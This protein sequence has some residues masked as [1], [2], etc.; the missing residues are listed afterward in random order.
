MIFSKNVLSTFASYKNACGF[1]Q[2]ILVGEEGDMD[3]SYY[4]LSPE[5]AAN[6]LQINIWIKRNCTQ[7]S[8]SH[9][10][11][12][13]RLSPNSLS[14]SLVLCRGNIS[15]LLEAINCEQ[16]LP[17]KRK[18]QSYCPEAYYEY[19]IYYFLIFQNSCKPIQ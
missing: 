6:F 3:E 18:T 4:S 8:I 17:L 15:N 12:C 7:N 9:I 5:P 16:A 14:C 10:N 2:T 1:G 19:L 13:F 11:I